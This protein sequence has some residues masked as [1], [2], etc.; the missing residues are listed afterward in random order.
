MAVS[1]GRSNFG[2]SLPLVV[3]LI[4]I[5]GV[6]CTPNPRIVNSAQTPETVPTERP[7][8]SPFESDLE[9]MRTADF[10]YIYVFR[11]KDGAVLD[12]DD[13]SFINSNKP[14]EV[15]RVRL[16]DSGKA[17]IFGSNFR[18]P[19]EALNNL[20]DRY[21]FQ[22]YSKPVAAVPEND[23]PKNTNER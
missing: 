8:A 22:D 15:N 16:S 18:L 2:I 6:A 12:N 20:I 21:A 10:N 11:R 23:G 9:A 5:F 7:Q 4:G 17:V 1:T 13:K 3:V 14:L 19:P